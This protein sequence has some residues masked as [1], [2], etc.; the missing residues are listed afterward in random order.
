MVYVAIILILS[1]V[2]AGLGFIIKDLIIKNDNFNRHEISFEEKYRVSGLPFAYLKTPNGKKWFLIDS[3]ANVN[4]LKRSYVEEIGELLEVK[5]SENQILTGSN[6]I[7]TEECMFNLS[8][9]RTKF[10]E[11]KFSIAELNAFD[12]KRD[13]WGIDVVGILG[14]PFLEKYNCTVCFDSM[15]FYITK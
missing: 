13:D 1:I 14:S 15:I 11:N 3:G 2:I 7:K 5:E 12:A 8:H 4:M 6:D 10:N 9:K